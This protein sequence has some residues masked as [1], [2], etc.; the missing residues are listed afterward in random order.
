MTRPITPQEQA[1][2]TTHQIPDEVFECV[3]AAL[4]TEGSG[5]RLVVYQDD[6]VK[7]L[8]EEGT[9]DRREIFEKHWLDFEPAYREAGWY[10]SYDKPAYNES[11]RAHWVFSRK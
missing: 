8:T 9:L 4:L 11:Y 10:V 7:K 5:R 3:N 6:I 2:Q 1:A